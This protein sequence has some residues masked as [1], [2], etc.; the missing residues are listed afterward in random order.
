MQDKYNIYLNDNIIKGSY[1]VL[2]IG[3]LYSKS[4]KIEICKNSHP[5]DYYIM[6]KWIE[7]NEELCDL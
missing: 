3:E 2:R 7:N 1:G 4:S 6:K 5:N